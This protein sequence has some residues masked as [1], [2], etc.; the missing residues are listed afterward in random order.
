VLRNP[1][2]I[3][4]AWL[5][6]ST[7]SAKTDFVPDCSPALLSGTGFSLCG[8]RAL[9]FRNSSFPFQS[10]SLTWERAAR[11]TRVPGEGAPLP[12]SVAFGFARSEASR[13]RERAANPGYAGSPTTAHWACDF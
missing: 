11:A 10:L 8:R 7:P 13:A 9:R 4:M 2:K 1:R 5:P 3:A 6:F 12:L